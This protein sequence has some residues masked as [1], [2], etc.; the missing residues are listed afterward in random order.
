MKK[1]LLLVTIF[2]FNAVFLFA[3]TEKEY[4]ANGM[5]AYKKGD[6]LEAIRIYTEMIAKFPKN[7]NAWNNRAYMYYL[8]NEDAKAIADY[9]KAI[10]INP[11][12]IELYLSRSDAYTSSRN[13]NAALA[14]L[15]KAIGMNPSNYWAWL[16]RGKAYNGKNLFE[17]AIADLTKAIS[18]KETA[19]AYMERGLSYSH[20]KK[21]DLA[22]A[23][24]D[25]AISIEPE[26]IDPYIDK[27]Q[28]VHLATQKYDEPIRILTEGIKKAAEEDAAKGYSNRGDFYLA[29]HDYAEALDDYIKFLAIAAPTANVL[30]NAGTAEYKLKKYDDAIKSFT[31]SITMFPEYISAYANRANVYAE[32]GQAA[33]GLADVESGL[34]ID[35]ENELVLTA[36][37]YCLKALGRNEEAQRIYDKY[38]DK[39]I[40]H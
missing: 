32:M 18:I 11:G 21:Y 34:A 39:F 22:I 40:K 24:F 28:T 14:D 23:D 38:K 6:R 1:Q 27:A 3:Q 13:Y 5:A 37:I 20:L 16:G 9:N 8:R 35:P 26:F 15:T 30:N 2:T 7:Q 10:E 31:Y 29:H 17:K 12:D 36:K 25:K 33:K 4:I 19:P